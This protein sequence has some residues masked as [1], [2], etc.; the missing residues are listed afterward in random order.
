LSLHCR[1]L[2][3]I[4]SFFYPS[5]K[6]LSILQRLFFVLLV[7]VGINALLL[8]ALE[9]LWL[10]PLLQHTTTTRFQIALLPPQQ[11]TVTSA[12]QTTPV[13]S[14]KAPVTPAAS[15]NTRSKP[16]PAQPEKPASPAPPQM[17]PVE[18][19]KAPVTPAA[20]VSTRSKPAPAQPE[21]S[22]IPPVAAEK[23]RRQQTPASA[24]QEKQKPILAPPP[25][26]TTTIADTR[27]AETQPSPAQRSRETPGQIGRPQT[28]K[29][30]LV[31]LHKTTPV[32]PRLAKRRGI[33]G[34]VLA[35]FSVDKEGVP[36][37]IQVLSAEPSGIFEKSATSALSRWRFMPLLASRRFQQRIDFRLQ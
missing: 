23:Q 26:D 28:K 30:Q 32:Y 29:E 17:P 3:W 36:K 5:L 25:A 12:S 8:M 35:E 33:E 31:V 24:N 22:E 18:S 16:A 10:P 11:Q 19:V 6:G 14:V 21:K 9:R 2:T 20:S 4:A 7:S 13:K 27:Q 15:V 34:F 37:N 1:G